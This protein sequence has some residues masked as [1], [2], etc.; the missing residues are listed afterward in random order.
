[1]YHLVL[2][3]RFTVIDLEMINKYSHM[4]RYLKIYLCLD[5]NTQEW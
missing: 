4:S 1:L 2:P 3:V 5:F